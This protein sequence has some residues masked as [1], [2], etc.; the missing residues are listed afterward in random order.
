MY[1]KSIGTLDQYN[2]LSN[3]NLAS[4]AEIHFGFLLKQEIVRRFNLL[5]L[6]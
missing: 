3:N 4:A 2:P 5:G 1:F 6:T